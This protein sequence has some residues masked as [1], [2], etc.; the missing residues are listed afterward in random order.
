MKKILLLFVVLMILIIQSYSKPNLSLT[1]YD[2]NNN[3]SD[4]QLILIDNNKDDVYDILFYNDNIHPLGFSLLIN[5]LNEIKENE[6]AYLINGKIE[7]RNFIIQ[8]YD[9]NYFEYTHKLYFDSKLSKAVL[10]DYT[11]NGIGQS[12]YEEADNYFYVQQMGSILLITKKEQIELNSLILCSLD[13]KIISNLQNVTGLNQFSFD[14]SFEPNGMY[15][16]RFH[17]SNKSLTK[18]VIFIR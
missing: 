10:E 15:I 3:F 17:S 14:M 1:V 2:V 12:T 13:G 16:L 6:I 7:S 11:G 18:R 5:S 9:P 4:E 8:L